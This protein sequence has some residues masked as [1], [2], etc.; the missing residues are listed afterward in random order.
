MFVIG[1]ALGGLSGALAAYW[2]GSVSNESFGLALAIGIFLMPIIGGV[3]SMWG[4][5]AG[6]L[7]YVGLP[8][9]L[10]DLDR[11][12]TLIYGVALVAAII[13]LPNGIIGGARRLRATVAGRRYRRATSEPDDREAVAHVER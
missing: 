4:P 13:L 2:Q 3:D 1:S 7:L 12:A 9:L 8:R 6:A 5:V 10:S 11:Y